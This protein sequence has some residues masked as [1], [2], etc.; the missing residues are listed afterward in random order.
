MADTAAYQYEYVSG[1]V[2]ILVPQSSFFWIDLANVGLVEESVQAVI[3]DDAGK[4]AWNSGVRTI[5]P[6]QL[7]ATGVGQENALIRDGSYHAR[8]FTN[9]PYVV[10]SARAYSIGDAG[11]ADLPPAL[12]VSVA[13]NDFARF[14]HLPSKVFPFPVDVGEYV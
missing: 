6:N 10:P 13:P 3:V 12:D 8:I 11:A 1:V 14:E 4:V 5:P 2:E 9:S 7:V